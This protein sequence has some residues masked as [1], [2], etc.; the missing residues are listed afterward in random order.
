MTAAELASHRRSRAI[1]FQLPTLP[2]E[3]ISVKTLRALSLASTAILFC[4]HAIAAG[5]AVAGKTVFEN[6]CSICHTTVVGKNGFGP[7]L[8]GVLGRRSGALAD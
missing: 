5:D 2:R 7:S 4:Q 1:E 3:C 8:A 6:Q